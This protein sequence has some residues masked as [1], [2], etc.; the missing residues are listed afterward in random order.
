[1]FLTPKN[2][3]IIIVIFI[4]NIMFCFYIYETKKFFF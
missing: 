2:V 3:I 4:N 1:M